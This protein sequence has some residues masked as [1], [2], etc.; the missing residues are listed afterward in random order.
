MP[1]QTEAPKRLSMNPATFVQGG[2]MNDVDVEVTA[3][4][5]M[6]F[7]YGGTS[8]EVPALE[9]TL[10]NLDDESEET[11]N[12]SAG[13]AKDFEPSDDGEYL[14]AVGAA[15][16]LRK[17][18]NAAHLLESLRSCSYDAAKLD[19]PA[20]A[21]VGLRMH[22]VRKPAPER[23]DMEGREKKEGGRK[24]TILV[25]TKIIRTPWEA[26]GG[27]GK[28]A[29]A[30]GNGKSATGSAKAQAPA[31]D[32]GELGEE[33]TESLT[34][35]LMEHAT[36]GITVANLKKIILRF[37]GTAALKQEMIKALASAEQLGGLD[38]AYAI[39]GDQI[40]LAEG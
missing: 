4:R 32:G 36:D 2:L 20:S 23:E 19:A 7:D 9:F 17:S 10:K 5:W 14:T 18:C 22:V 26:K 33:A 34:G 29:T 31:N 35:I 21:F 6:M 24:P 8:A 11:Q 1:T 30:A 15:T 3:A 37:K 27:K 25:C 12:W 16:G 39:N 28:T 40:V 38:P 13:A